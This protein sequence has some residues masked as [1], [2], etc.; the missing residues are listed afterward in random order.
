MG[1][2]RSD[3]S[4]VRR[5]VRELAGRALRAWKDRRLVIVV[6]NLD[7]VEAGDARS[8]WSTLQ[9]FLEPRH[10]ETEAWLGQLWVMIPYDRQALNAL[11]DTNAATDDE[12]AS[13]VA[14]GNNFLEK[15]MQ[16]RFAV[17]PAVLSDWRAYVIDTLQRAFP[18]HSE[19]EFVHVYQVFASQSAT[20]LA[21]PTPR[22]L[23]LFVNGIGALHRQWEDTFP[24][25]ALAYF[26]LLRKSGKENADI[27]SD[28]VNSNIPSARI[29]YLL[30]PNPRD[31]LAAMVYNVDVPRATELLLRQPIDNAL[32]GLDGP[33]LAQLEK[34]FPGFWSVLESTEFDNFEKSDQSLAAKFLA[35]SGLLTVGQDQRA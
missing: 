33:D 18:Q 29:S 16:V 3:L 32:R 19:P 27:A 34:S 23:K 13:T 25:S 6:D 9:T 31:S 11:W 10:R 15:R 14:V 4:R 17:P 21:M 2:S 1:G 7:R 5:V 8:I 35:N 20:H 30:G 26:E 12:A 22:E 28:L 24:L